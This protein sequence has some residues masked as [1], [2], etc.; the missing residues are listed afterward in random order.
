MSTVEALVENGTTRR[1]PV[2]LSTVVTRSG[3]RD[4]VAC[5]VHR[6][7]H[8]DAVVLLV[9]DVRLE[10]H[11]LAVWRQRRFIGHVAVASSDAYLVARAAAI[12]D[13]VDLVVGLSR[14]REH[15]QLSVFVP[16]GPG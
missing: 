7:L 12:V 14:G 4:V 3:E 9:D 2:G 8:D 16:G 13:R 15:D 6:V 10:D 1:G 5:S 11:P